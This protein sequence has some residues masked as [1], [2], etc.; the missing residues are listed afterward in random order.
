MNWE[1]FIDEKLTP[2]YR[3]VTHT[4]RRR[5]LALSILGILAFLAAWG[6]GTW[7][8]SAG[9]GPTTSVA[10][11]VL[12]GF[13]I[14]VLSLLPLTVAGIAVALLVWVVKGTIQWAWTGTEESSKKPESKVRR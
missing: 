13:G 9:E 11:T 1:I 8:L 6:V 2:V 14:L 12:L 5:L 10:K 3:R 7:I 4:R